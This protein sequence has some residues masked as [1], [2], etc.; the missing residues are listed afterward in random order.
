MPDTFIEVCQ[1]LISNGERYEEE[2]FLGWAKLETLRSLCR[3]CPNQ[4]LMIRLKCRHDIVTAFQTL[5]E[6]LLRSLQS[7]VQ[8]AAD[9]PLPDRCAVDASA[10]LRLYCALKLYDEEGGLLLKLTTCRPPPTEA[11]LRFV[12]LG[13]CMLMACPSLIA[14]PE[15]EQSGKMVRA[16][17]YFEKSPASSSDKCMETTRSSFGEMLL[18]MA[19]HFHSGQLSA[20]CDRVVTSHAVRESV[21]PGLNAD[22]AGF[23]LVHASISC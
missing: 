6:E 21:T 19:I 10:L 15:Q 9:E 12:A 1:S 22:V 14:L 20:V 2:S 18:L 3:M 17:S 5:R 23:L 8:M 11:D 7:F 4:I 16:E 13:L